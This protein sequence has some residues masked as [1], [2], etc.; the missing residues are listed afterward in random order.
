MS[1]DKSGLRAARLVIIRAAAFLVVV[2]AVVNA[3]FLSRGEQQGF[4]LWYPSLGTAAA[5]VTIAVGLL[6]PLVPARVVRGGAGV[7]LALYVGLVALFPLAALVG[8]VERMPW[9]LTASSAAVAT[10]LVAGG[11]S[12]GWATILFAATAGVCYRL[13]FGGF[14]VDGIINDVHAALTASVICVLGGYVLSVGEGL[15]EA[16]AVRRAAGS[17]EYAERGR[18]AA[19]T[20]TAALVHD[21]ALATFA[22]AASPL[23]VPRDRLAA[24]ARHAV[25][26]L[27]RLVDDAAGDT[28][29]FEAALV[30]EARAHGAG[31][32]PPAENLPPLPAAV[33]EAFLGA[34]RQ[35][36]DNSLRHARGASRTVSVRASE[37]TIEVEVVDDGDGFD[38]SRIAD[39]RLGVRQSILGRMTRVPGG[40]ARVQSAPGAGTRVVLSYTPEPRDEVAALGDRRS[41]R[42]GV[43]V[44]GVGFVALQTVCA[45]TMVIEAP[46]SWLRQLTILVV[47]IVAA[48]A[49][50][51][52]PGFVP[53]R[54]R[55]AVI[56]A[57]AVLGAFVTVVAA[58]TTYGDLWPVV[59]LAFLLVGLALRGRFGT[60]LAA[61]AAVAAVVIVGGVADGVPIGQILALT[62]RPAL[63]VVV[64]T[65]MLL[66]VRRMQ[67]R[68]AAL[69][70]QAAAAEEQESWSRGAREELRERT[71]ELARTVVPLLSRIAEGHPA[72]VDDR[73][74]YAA[75][76]GALRDGLRAGS[77]SREPLRGAVAAARGRGV[78][79]ALLDDSDQ[80][81]S[82]AEVRA[83]V[84]WMGDAIAR[85]ERSVVGRLLPPGR[86]AVASVTVDGR[87]LMF[88]GVDQGSVTSFHGE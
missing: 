83:V 25:D 7:A 28:A 51:R 32:F 16:A 11:V 81:L 67:R 43:T 54:R 52:S 76:E 65:L 37:G 31:Y 5:A 8:H 21:E 14:D 20:R 69:H 1:D 27:T 19:R 86:R 40:Q 46:S 58:P 61:A 44:V 71:D 41:L 39:D 49:L 10:A 60:A 64:A 38:P 87:A 88:E 68:I 70:H 55:A 62:A 50:R 73:R 12:W 80:S 47:V 18:L 30:A 23:P 72:S 79:V 26:M 35:A 6:A 3:G 42:R 78:D 59:A 24:Q 22:L 9:L 75:L 17:R 36:L 84:S 53:S 85:A 2:V 57:T 33:G 45:M 29:S 77:L 13:A 56:V 48:E 82:E 66:T 4:P 34:V 15:D 74:E 63:I